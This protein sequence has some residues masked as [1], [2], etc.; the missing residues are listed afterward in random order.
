MKL[1]WK[2][3]LK[4]GVTATL[5]LFALYLAQ[6]YWPRFTSTVTLF[7]GTLAPLLIGFAIAYVVNILMSSYERIYFPHT[8]NKFLRRSRRIVC[9]V[10]A[11]LSVI[12]IAGIVIGLILPELVECVELLLLQVPGVMANLI[13]TVSEW[14]ILPPEFLN[15]LANLN[16][17]TTV[18]ELISAF[19]GGWGDVV[20]TVIGTVK[21]VFSGAV[22]TLHPGRGV[23]VCQRD[24]CHHQPG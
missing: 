11:Y 13:E 1:T 18:Q 14:E 16:W 5:S 23:C 19:T 6:Y 8:R 12:L 2:G 22:T 3:C 7:F 4:V 10:L 24:R 20:S 9:M 17:F 15:T 21:L